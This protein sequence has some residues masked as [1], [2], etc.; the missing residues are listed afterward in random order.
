MTYNEL[1]DMCRQAI[2]M[3]D[4]VTSLSEVIQALNYHTPFN[5]QIACEKIAFLL[6][7]FI[8]DPAQKAARPRVH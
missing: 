5:R 2:C 6:A 4:D 3:R 1:L 7:E 8:E